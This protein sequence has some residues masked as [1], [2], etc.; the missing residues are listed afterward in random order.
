PLFQKRGLSPFIWNILLPTVV[1][2]FYY[3]LVPEFKIK[4]FFF[5][6]I[7]FDA[8]MPEHLFIYVVY[9]L[10]AWVLFLRE[11]RTFSNAFFLLIFLLFLSSGCLI[12]AIHL[13]TPHFQFGFFDRYLIFLVPADILMFSLAAVDLWR[14]S[15]GNVWLNM[16]I[17][18]LLGGLTVIRGLMTYRAILGSA[19]YLH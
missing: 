1:F 10:I 18:I 17:I 11:K 3:L 2:L 6:T 14:W 8:V 12:M 16:N 4:T 15:R 5:L 7:L 19:L 13:F 9:A